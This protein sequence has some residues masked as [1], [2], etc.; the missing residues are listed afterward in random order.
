M[1]PTDNRDLDALFAAAAAP[2]FPEEH[3]EQAL[4]VVLAAFNAAGLA[5]CD[6]GGAKAAIDCRE[7]TARRTP[8]NR[9]VMIAKCVAMF[10][11]ATGGGVAAAGAGIL[12][13]SAQ[14]LAHQ[15]LG[16][17]GVPAPNSDGASQG[18]AAPTST[19]SASA[20]STHQ[21]LSR[22]RG[23]ASASATPGSVTPSAMSPA[24]LSLCS[25]VVDDSDWQSEMSGQDLALLTAAA[26]GDKKI[27]SYC[28]QVY[29]Q[30][31]GS[32]TT[33]SGDSGSASGS[34]GDGSSDGNG[35]SDSASP[36]A[37]APD[38]NGGPDTNASPNANATGNGHGG[39]GSRGGSNGGGGGGSGSGGSGGGTGNSQDGGG[40]SGGSNLGSTP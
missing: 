9:T 23:A 31:Q 36:S 8:R 39:G 26:G 18:I 25:Q 35:S 24:V 5:E 28:A 22:S 10:L 32:A 15:F 27:T 13:A 12:P 19:P 7:R 38:G 4:T 3:D 17:I 20:T 14:S 6:G 37:T 30:A 1:T 40:G 21:V 29:A 33:P 11:I 34:P 2:A 16:G